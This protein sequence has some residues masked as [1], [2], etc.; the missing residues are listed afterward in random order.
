[1]IVLRKLRLIS[2]MIPAAAFISMALSAQPHDVNDPFL[3]LEEVEGEEA[4][5]WVHA[6]NQATKETIASHPAFEPIRERILEILNSEDRIPFP[7]IQGEY[8]YNFWQDADN[9]RGIWRR[10]TWDQYLAGG[11]D[12]ETMLDIDKLTQTEN[13]P[14][15]YR[16]S[17]CLAPEYR[18]CLVRLSRGGADAV[19]IREYD[20][21]TKRFID[22]GFFLPE[23]KQNVSWY[24]ENTLLVATDFG[25]GSLTTS[26]YARVAKKWKRGTD[27]AEAQTLF[28]GEKSDVSVSVGSYRS[29]DRTYHYVMHR[30]SFFKGTAYILMDGELVPMELPLDASPTLMADRLVVRLRTP[31]ETGGTTYPE[32]ALISIGIEDFLEGDRN[33]EVI[34]ETGER[35][36]IRSVSANRSALLVSFLDNVRTELRRYTYTGTGWQYDSIEAPEFGTVSFAALSP[37]TDRFFFTSSGFTQPTTLYLAEADGTSRKVRSLPDMFNAEGLVVDQ[38]TAVSKD[39]TEIP[40]FIVHPENIEYDGSN[41]TLLHA[42]GGFG[43]SRTPGYNSTVGATW[44]EKGGVYVVANI[45]GGGE[46]GPKWHRAAQRENRQRAYDDFIAVAEDLIERGITSPRHLGIQG[47]S[48]GGL[49]VGVA[50]TQ[51]PDLFG[52]VVCSVPLLDMRRYHTL[53]AGASW[54]AEYGNPDDPNDWE[55]IGEYSPYQNLEMEENYPRVLFTTTT[56]DDRV[57]PGHARKMAARMEKM[58]HPVYYFENTE[59]GHGAGVTNEQRA[60]MSAI[61]YTYLWKE[62]SKER[63]EALQNRK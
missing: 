24:D 35:N 25:E 12:W 51:R 55:F 42:Y 28:A 27:L 39:G 7:S 61:T 16:G 48:N 37:Y 14:W 15:A 38:R 43:I 62:L 56:R 3:W 13:V 34:L 22:D 41:P 29:A 10:M 23:A 2:S 31:W 11:S 20:T 6:R 45:R 40:Y 4:L 36:T 60:L 58:G 54:M 8:L 47:G 5:S 46:Y 17:T 59:G 26:G 33:F 50:F 32:D 21:D 63:E 57:H 52:A 30:P 44:L 19:E 9:P 18:R 53:L 1:M 49:L